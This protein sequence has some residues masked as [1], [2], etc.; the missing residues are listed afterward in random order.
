MSRT[1]SSA[2][3]L[4]RLIKECKSENV[5]ENIYINFAD[6]FVSHPILTLVW[7]QPLLALRTDSYVP[8][9]PVTRTTFVL[10]FLLETT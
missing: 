8:L 10:H 6:E 9:Q 4:Q 5:A 1:G 3:R 7:L 2:H